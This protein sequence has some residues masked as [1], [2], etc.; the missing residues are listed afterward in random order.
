MFYEVAIIKHQNGTQIDGEKLEE[1]D[2]YRYKG[3]QLT[4]D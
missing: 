3:R 2:D 1:M 4:P